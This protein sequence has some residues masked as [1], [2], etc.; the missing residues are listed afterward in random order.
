[1]LLIFYICSVQYETYCMVQ[2]LKYFFWCQSK[3]RFLAWGGPRQG[4]WIPGGRV[5]REQRQ[6]LVRGAR[7]QDQRQ[8]AQTDTQEVPSEHQET[9]CVTVMGTGWPREVA[10]SPTTDIFNWTWPCVTGAQW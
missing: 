1:M 9:L 5:W 4:V 3:T 7:W 2:K 10:G 8:W 6:A